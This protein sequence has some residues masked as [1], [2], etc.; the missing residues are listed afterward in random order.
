MGDLAGIVAFPR[1]LARAQA[2]THAGQWE[3]AAQLWEQVIAANP[4]DGRFWGRLGDAH[5]HLQH[6]S[7]AATAYQRALDLGVSAYFGAT[8]HGQGFPF[9]LAYRI[10]CCYI[11]LGDI[12][13]AATWLARTLDRGYRDIAAL[14]EDP[15]LAPLHVRPEVRERLGIADLS[16]VTREEGWRFDLALVEREVKRRMVDPHRLI[17][18]GRFDAAL[19]ALMAAIPDLTDAQIYV[20]LRR[21]IRLV[22]DGHSLVGRDPARPDLLLTL[23]VQFY[24][25]AEG[26]YIIAAAREHAGLLGKRVVALDGQPI[27][28]VLAALEPLI[29]RDNDQW[30]LHQV[31][32]AVRETPVLH[33]LG[34]LDAPDRASLTLASDDGNAETVALA[35]DLDQPTH[36]LYY[37]FPAPPSWMYL[38]ETLSF[39]PPL[40][41]RNPWVH[42]WFEHLPQARAVY[43]Q[44]NRVREEPLEPFPAFTERLFACIAANRVDKLVIDLRWN[45][46]GNTFLTLPFL[47]R[48]I[49]AAQVNR[50][51]GL[52]VIIGRRTYS[53]AQNFTTM[54]ELHTNAT[55]VGEPSGSCPNFAGETSEFR[56]PYSGLTL[57]IS[58]LYWQT[59]WPTDHRSATPPLLYIP[60]T[61]TAFAANRDPALEAVLALDSH[62]AG[63]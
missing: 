31:P 50:R 43:F 18:A 41:L 40:Y 58:D 27:E 7:A 25:F 21:L 11:R 19:R 15:L 45:N 14:R 23:P 26:L 56:L 16:G 8:D 53:A 33:A 42:Y 1:L 59:S 13:T 30:V 2:A 35:A 12:E 47:H 3:D 55:F 24:L 34:L 10:T 4:T 37:A 5:F 54:L 22:G 61:F 52:F 51:G 9:D 48:L 17:R 49:G 32:F 28:A 39:P 38:P 62:L 36:R 44:F 20:E 29:S 6:D 57:N 63:I 46:G 60:P